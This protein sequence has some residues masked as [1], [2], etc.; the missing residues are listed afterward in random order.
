[1][2]GFSPRERPL[3]FYFMLAFIISWGGSF[4]A[5]GPKFLRGESF[6]LM[7]AM[8]MFV[9]MLLGPSVAG[10]VTIASVERNQGL[11]DLWARMT[12]WRVPGL[13]YGIAV[14]TP[15][16]LIVLVLL[17]L[18]T[19]IAPSF[20]PTFMPPMVMIG[21]LAGYFE[22]IGWMGCAFPRMESRHGALR[23]GIVLGIVWSSWHVVA[24]FIGTSGSAGALW[25]PHFLV[26]SAAMTAMRMLIVWVYGHTRSVLLA[27]LMHASS[28][29]S[30][31]VF[32]PSLSTRNDLLFYAAYAAILLVMALLVALKGGY[33]FSTEDE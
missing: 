2:K 10:I 3:L 13:W 24:D 15:P 29:G 8:V 23:A 27:Q 5:A 6:G 17:L 7:D 22:E 33:R 19:A 12:K 28:T 4:A 26:W 20:T 30:L 21:V 1:M 31:G 14:L 32:V 11:R 25:L 9:P 18:R 16:I